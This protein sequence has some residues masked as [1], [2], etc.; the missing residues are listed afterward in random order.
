MVIERKSKGR[1]SEKIKFIFKERYKTKNKKTDPTLRRFAS[2]FS[3]FCQEEGR[4]GNQNKK[5]CYHREMAPP[6]SGCSAQV[7]RVLIQVPCKQDSHSQCSVH[8][9]PWCPSLP[10]RLRQSNTVGYSMHGYLSGAQHEMKH[11]EKRSPF[12]KSF[13]NTL[14][15]VFQVLLKDHYIGFFCVF[16]HAG[17]KTCLYLPCARLRILPPVLVTPGIGDAQQ[18]PEGE[19]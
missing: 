4:V 12:T 18:K 15:T 9:L 19:R 2:F 3:V 8:K 17:R 13:G 16:L 5:K 10:G 14:S 11:Q 6:G 7:G 1:N